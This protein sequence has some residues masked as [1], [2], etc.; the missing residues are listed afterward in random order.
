M[1]VEKK[2]AFCMTRVFLSSRMRKRR[3]H[4]GRDWFESGA[5]VSMLFWI[6][7]HDFVIAGQLFSE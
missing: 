7:N 5:V 4:M 6:L 1:E 2:T 3:M